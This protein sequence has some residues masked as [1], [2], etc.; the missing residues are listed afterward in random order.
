MKNRWMAAE[1]A[2]LLASVLVLAACGSDDGDG[3]RTSGGDV[4][5]AT[6]TSSGSGS[7]S[8]TGLSGS[9]HHHVHER[10]ARG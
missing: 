5:D 8:A 9:D 4:R 10:G 6:N 2:G 7:G 3:V 1:I